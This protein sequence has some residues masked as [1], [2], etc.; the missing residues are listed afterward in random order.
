MSFR[1]YGKFKLPLTY[2]GKNVNWYLLLSHCRYFG[3][4]N[5]KCLLN[6]TIFVQTP[7]NSLVVMAMKMLICEKIFKKIKKKINSSEAIKGINLKL[8]RN[9]HSV[10]L[11]KKHCFLLPLLM[12]FVAMATSNFYR[13]IMGKMK[14]GF[15]CCLI[16]GILTE[17]F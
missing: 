12:L 6:G 1:C 8:C 15:N 3:K 4:K 5:Q 2:N 10:S 9:G 17:R 7:K 16:A 11:Y 14:I 13:L